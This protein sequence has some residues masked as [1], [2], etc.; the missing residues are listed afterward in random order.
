MS[1][2]IQP[3]GPS[4]FPYPQTWALPFNPQVHHC[5]LT[6]RHEL[7]HSTHWS[8]AALLPTDRSSPIYS[9]S[10]LPFNPLVHHCFFPTETSFPIQPTGPSLLPSSRQKLSHSVHWSITAHLPTHVSYPLNPLVSH[11]TLTCRH[12]LSHSTHCSI[13]AF[14]PTDISSPI[15]PTD[16]SLLP[17]LQ[18]G[19]LPFNPMVHHC[20]LNYRS[21]LFHSTHWSTTAS[22]H[23]DRNSPIQSTGPSLLTYQHAWAIQPNPLVSHCI[24]TCRHELSHSTHWS[25][26]TFLPADMNFPIQ[27]TG[28]SLLSYLQTGALPFNPLVRYCFLDWVTVRSFL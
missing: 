7:S 17:Y 25:I 2:P 19:A 23:Q 22:L 10:A 13:T 3:T 12:E 18:T 27:P 20:F 9:T 21:K 8:I 26:I 16:P 24:L 4:L 1:S 11:C 15:Q 28:Q 6:N 14:L 5:F